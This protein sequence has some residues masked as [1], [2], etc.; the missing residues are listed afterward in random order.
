M[1]RTENE[2]RTEKIEIEEKVTDETNSDGQCLA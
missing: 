1:K 2:E